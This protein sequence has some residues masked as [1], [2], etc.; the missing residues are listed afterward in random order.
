MRSKKKP[1]KWEIFVDGWIEKLLWAWKLFI[2]SRFVLKFSFS[3]FKLSMVDK[4]LSRSSKNQ[5]HFSVNFHAIFIRL[6]CRRIGK[7]HI[8]AEYATINVEWRMIVKV[9]SC[10]VPNCKWRS[11]YLMLSSTGYWM[12][13]FFGFRWDIFVV[14]LFFAMPLRN[15]HETCLYVM[16]SFHSPFLVSKH[17]LH[18]HKLISF[19]FFAFIKKR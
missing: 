15:I 4:Y 5:L 12:C 9:C 8:H 18:E 1:S 19:S 11:Y 17:T 16:P 7:K 2:F 10:Y 14:S 3:F 13:L 6:R